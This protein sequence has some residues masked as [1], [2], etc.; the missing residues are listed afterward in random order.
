MVRLDRQN[1]PVTA[2]GF[3]QPPRL[4]VR[5]AR[6]EQFGSARNGDG[7][8]SHGIVSC[9]ISSCKIAWRLSKL[10][11]GAAVTTVHVRILHAHGR[12]G[13]DAVHQRCHMAR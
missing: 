1:P 8:G 4:M 10:G 5:D 7:R 2:L 3:R 13:P 9:R 11:G 6:R 12:P